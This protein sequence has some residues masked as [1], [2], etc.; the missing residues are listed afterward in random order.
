MADP[1]PSDGTQGSSPV[2]AQSALPH[3]LKEKHLPSHPSIQTQ[4]RRPKAALVGSKTG[5]HGCCPQPDA[6]RMW[7]V[8]AHVGPLRFY[9]S[10]SVEPPCRPAAFAWTPFLSET[11]RRGFEGANSPEIHGATCAGVAHRGHLQAFSVVTL[12]LPRK[13]TG[14]LQ[15][16]G[17]LDLREKVP[18]AHRWKKTGSRGLPIPRP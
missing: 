17:L 18:D 8:S 7:S 16:T 15:K 2:P 6:C 4:A 5:F 14:D 12:T 10:R 3:F 1:I 11:R 13:A 9:S